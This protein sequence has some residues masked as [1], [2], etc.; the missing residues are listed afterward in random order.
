MNQAEQGIALYLGE[1]CLNYLQTVTIGIAGAGGLGSN[2]AMHL[3]RSGFKKFVIADFDR[4]DESNLNRQ[5]YRLDQVG[6]LKVMALS[7][8]MLAVNP[9]LELDLRT[10][11]VT[12]E[13]IEALFIHCDVVIEAFDSPSFKKMIVE[14]FIATDKVVVTASGMGGAGNMESM[15]TRRVRDNLYMIG[16][17]ETECCAEMPPLSPK[18]GVAAAMQADAVLHHYLEE[19]RKQGGA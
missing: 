5:A 6:E 7:R 10:V 2:C 16:D 1:E 14:K 3:V 4:V 9:D 13:N 15:K 19:F 18:V 11:S 12:P 8:N 17:M